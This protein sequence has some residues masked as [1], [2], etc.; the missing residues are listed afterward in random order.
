MKWPESPTPRG[1]QVEFLHPS[2]R[3]IF[4]TSSQ[5]V[6]QF[7]S[8]FG[9]ASVYL[10]AAC[11]L[12]RVR[13]L[14]KSPS[15]WT[16]LSNPWA[17]THLGNWN[18]I[19]Y[20]IWQSFKY[21]TTHIYD[22]LFS[23]PYIYIYYS[24]THSLFHSHNRFYLNNN[25]VPRLTTGPRDTV[26]HNNYSEEFLHQNE[27]YLNVLTFKGISFS[28]LESSFMSTICDFFSPP[29]SSS[30]VNT[31]L[32]VER[33]GWWPHTLGPV[34]CALGVCLFSKGVSP[35]PSAPGG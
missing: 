15:H 34:P 27:R 5:E 32:L 3:F 17:S 6:F 13:V 19:P 8:K 22:S 1:Q 24:L 29:T 21:L 20:S 30:V 4:T 23:A 2:Q 33:A 16:K 31:V 26:V 11:V 35:H 14:G 25:H 7:L 9:Q 10:G 18:S 12:W 28:Y